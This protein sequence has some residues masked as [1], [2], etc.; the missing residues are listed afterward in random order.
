MEFSDSQEP[1]R[2]AQAVGIS[3]RR[4]LVFSGF[5]CMVYHENRHVAFCRFELQPELLLNGRKE[6]RPARVRC[7]VTLILPSECQRLAILQ[8]GTVEDGTA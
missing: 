5:L 8:A 4:S 3:S 1:S 7:C 6:G 2:V